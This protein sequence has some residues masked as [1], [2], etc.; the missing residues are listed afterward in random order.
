ML[1]FLADSK[2]MERPKNGTSAPLP[3]ILAARLCQKQRKT[4]EVEVHL[5]H[6]LR[7][8]GTPCQMAKRQTKNSGLGSS[9]VYDC[10]MR[11]NTL[12][13]GHRISAERCPQPPNS[14]AASWG[15]SGVPATTKCFK[16][17]PPTKQPNPLLLIL[18]R[19]WWARAIAWR[20]HCWQRFDEVVLKCL[21]AFILPSHWSTIGRGYN[22]KWDHIC[23]MNLGPRYFLWT[24]SSADIFTTNPPQPSLRPSVLGH[25]AIVDGGHSE[26]HFPFGTDSLA[27]GLDLQTCFVCR[28]LTDA[29][30]AEM[31][32]K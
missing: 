20:A 11:E 23:K 22:S 2:S 27:T 10:D 14:H 4:A 7:H 28:A 1:L 29:N 13:L 12:L 9:V 18:I 31:R 21:E 5:G 30:T 8:S 19:A 32:I 17:V 25:K 6:N 15:L 16:R 26:T 3:Q 24:D